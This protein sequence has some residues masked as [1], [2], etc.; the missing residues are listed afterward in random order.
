MDTS[1]KAA[2]TKTVKQLLSGQTP[3]DSSV[4]VNGWVRTRRDSKAG[5]SFV[6]VHDGSCFA[7]VQL[8]CDTGLENYEDEVKSLT[9]GCSVSCRG[10]LVASQGK[11][12]TYEIKAEQL[13]VIGWV[14]EPDSYPLAA[15]H[16]T[17][18]HLRD[19]A[20]LR[21][22]AN[23][24]GAGARVRNTIAQAIHR[25]FH[26]RGFVWVNTPIITANDC[27]GAGELFRVSTLDIANST[28]AEIDFT[29]DFFGTE[30]FLTV[31]GQLNV[32]SYCLAL[33]KVYTF[34]PTFRA[35]QS[36]TSRHLAEF[37]MVE[38]EVAFADLS[39]NATLAED[40]LKYIFRTVL[41]EAAEDMAFFVQQID[42]QAVT[43]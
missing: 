20:H 2:L 38:P 14:D 11:N 23:T 35:E 24:I 6:H 7:P 37:W 3:V 13:E 22:R 26:T 40:F 12:Q 25:Y 16:H 43:P 19:V 32:E 10:R 8:V 27:E 29:N 33:S 5:F 39:D 17:F 30:T 28:E 1:T 36:N 42:K 18:E 9:A 31:S 41:D 15:K 4:I 34:G 21:P